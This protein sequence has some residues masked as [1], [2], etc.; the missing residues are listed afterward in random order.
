MT[1]EIK[2]NPS[3]TAAVAAQGAAA[4]EQA[5]VQTEKQV[6]PLLGGE[7]VKVTSVSTSF[8]EKL[9]ARLKNE[10][11]N[12]QAGVAQKRLMAVMCALDTA[13][14]RVTQEKAA[15]LEKLTEAQVKKDELEATQAELYA[16]YGIGPGDNA[17]VV[18]DMKIKALEEAV[19]RAVQEGKDHNEAVEKAKEK[20]ERARADKAKMES[21]KS[22]IADAAAKISEAMEII[23][24]ATMKEIAEALSTVAE[25]AGSP[26]VATR[27]AEEEK[28]EK[29]EVALDFANAISKAL[30]KIEE[31]LLS[32]IEENR[33]VQ[34]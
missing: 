18:M 31:A 19:E 32:R 10:S 27:P 26:E 1:T 29:K 11:E 13:N 17:S 20:L 15:A 8:L 9:V 24:A 7:N 12:T 25:D 4:G 21:C 28:E 23:G 22:G 34:V 3:L 16:A 5:P 14:V 33:V 6:A 30:D 2:F